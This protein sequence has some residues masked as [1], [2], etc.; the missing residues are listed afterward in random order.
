VF[1]GDNDGKVS[2]AS[3]RLPEM[4]DHLVVDSGHTFIMN[5]GEVIRQVLAFLRNGSF[6]KSVD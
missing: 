3:T 1:N 2:V 5:D 4:K 6:L